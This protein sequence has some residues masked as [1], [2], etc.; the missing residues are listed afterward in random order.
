MID[1]IDPTVLTQPPDPMS[2]LA[3]AVSKG[4]DADQL[5]KLVAMQER[6]EQRQ[7]ELAFNRALVRLQARAPAVVRDG[8]NK[9]TGSR[10]A[11]LEAISRAVMPVLTEEG[12][13]LSFAELDA[14]IPGWKRNIC[15]VRHTG[16]FCVRYQLDLPLD[17]VGGKGNAIAGMN[18]VQAAVSTGTYGQRVLFCR[19]LNLPIVG[20]DIDGNLPEPLLSNEQIAEVNT[21]VDKLQR[22]N[23][24]WSYD[25]F[26]AWL[27]ITAID[28]L[29]Q[30]RLGTALMDLNTR[31]RAAA[32][33]AQQAALDA[34]QRGT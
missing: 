5:G 16:G 18:P 22:F 33:K 20:S 19:I 9:I 30:A 14:P 27:R 12:F 24:Q 15:D 4:I 26:L 31:L 23:P 7:A 10:Y 21:L 3:Q 8:E 13:A 11:T 1:T 6:W 34:T 32:G 28:Q 25:R 17:G 2:I 29:P